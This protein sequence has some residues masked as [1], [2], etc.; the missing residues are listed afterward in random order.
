MKLSSMLL[1]VLLS[2]VWGHSTYEQELLRLIVKGHVTRESLRMSYLI[3][4]G[5]FLSKHFLTLIN[6]YDRRLEQSRH[7]EHHIDKKTSSRLPNIL[8]H[9]VGCC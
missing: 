4:F 8:A 7:L 5:D 9:D 3:G 2:G 1:E 6:Q